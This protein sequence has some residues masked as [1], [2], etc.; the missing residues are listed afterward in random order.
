M[1]T[2]T[3]SA[4]ASRVNMARF[5]RRICHSMSNRSGC[6]APNR[7]GCRP[8]ITGGRSPATG[9]GSGMLARLVASRGTWMF[10]KSGQT[11]VN[12]FV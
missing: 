1:S 10:P 5:H 2:I 3:S 4:I 12:L 9:L 7:S 6:D 8:G 11:I